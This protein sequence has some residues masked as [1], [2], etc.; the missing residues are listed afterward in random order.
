M[1]VHNSLHEPEQG[2]LEKLIK[3]HGSHLYVSPSHCAFRTIK[4]VLVGGFTPQKLAN[5]TDWSL[6]LFLVFLRPVVKH[7][8]LNV[9]TFPVR[10]T[11][12]RRIMDLPQFGE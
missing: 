6:F 7:L 12:A 2:R 10:P 3:V 4:S 5:A 9:L 11:L 8:Q 1:N